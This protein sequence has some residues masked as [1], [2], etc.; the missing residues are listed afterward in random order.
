MRKERRSPLPMNDLVLCRSRVFAGNNLQD[1]KT[2]ETRG[3]KTDATEIQYHPFILASIVALG[4][5]LLMAA[6]D[7]QAQIAFVS[8]RDGSSEIYVMDNDGG[9]P[10]RLSDNRFAEWDPSWSLTVNDSLYLQWTGR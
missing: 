1:K 3:G 5:T 4:M 6:V 8:D 10:R 7:A 2:I 9:N